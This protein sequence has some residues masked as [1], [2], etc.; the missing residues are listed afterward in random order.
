[1]AAPGAHSGASFRLKP[2][3][4]NGVAYLLLSLAVLCWAG[5]WVIARALRFEAPPAAM[6][7]WRW[8]IAA[9][10]LLPLAWR[11]L[12]AQW[13]VIRQSWKI[14]CVLALLASTLQHIPVYQGLHDTTAINGAILNA[15]SPVFIALL[16]V[17]VGEALRARSAVG[18]AVALCGVVVVISGGDPR[19]LLGLQA[20]VGDI[21]VLVGMLSWSAYNVGLRW[22]PARLDRLATLAL[23]SVI[24][25]AATA[26]FYVVEMIRGENLE[27]T[28]GSL[29]GLVY[30]GV[31]ASVVAYV[32]WNAA[33]DRVGATRAGP[34]MYLM[35]V[36]TPLLAIAF[37]G[38]RLYLYHFVGAALIVGGIVVAT[39]QSAQANKS[40]P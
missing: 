13:S 26:P 39:S 1:L 12:H 18:I 36:F 17:L 9:L 24:G 25:A 27:V 40:R 30:M 14:L 23:I 37:L 22:R 21:W 10:V 28:A 32:F 2:P 16:A 29:A 31:F 4:S 6:T 33:V 5:N 19:L 20:N 34:F 11:S 7:F 35:P 15:T 3:S 38:E 8:A